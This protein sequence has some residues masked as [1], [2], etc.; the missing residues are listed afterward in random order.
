MTEKVPHVLISVRL[1]LDQCAAR[2]SFV[3]SI[4]SGGCK[5]SQFRS[6]PLKDAIE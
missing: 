5:M 4:Y 3:F 2:I 6:R 1:M